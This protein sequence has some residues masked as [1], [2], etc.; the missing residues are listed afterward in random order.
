[1]T[2]YGMTDRMVGTTAALFLVLVDTFY[3]YIHYL[4][5]EYLFALIVWPRL[6]LQRSRRLSY[7][8]VHR[9]AG[10]SLHLSS[11]T[12]PQSHP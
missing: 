7:P 4:Q 5:C 3:I 2:H 8:P 11:S 1:M 9:P 12:T 6:C 10:S